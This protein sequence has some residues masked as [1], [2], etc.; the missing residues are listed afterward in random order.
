MSH[1]VRGLGRKEWGTS[2][3]RWRGTLWGSFLLVSA[4]LLLAGCP[5][6]P[7]VQTGGPGAAG[8]P[9]VARPGGQ[10]TPV[11]PAK[12]GRDVFFDFDKSTIRPDAKV[13][14]DKNIAWLQSESSIRVLVEGHCD[15][16]GTQEY[17]L[18]LGERRAKA[19]KDY[20]V[21]GGIAANRIDT[22]SYGK[23]RPFVL[24]HD[25]SAWKWNRRGHF[26]VK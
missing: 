23:E 15:E 26:V 19:V 4:A 16:R 25:E 21:A 2:T 5:K 18:A 17:N 3:A 1:H 14:L 10:E 7:E 20:L 9:G 13:T 6:K 12:E 8:A 11:E 22:I 24:G